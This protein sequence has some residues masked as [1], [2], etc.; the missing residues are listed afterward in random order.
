MKISRGAP[1]KK[2]ARR[3]YEIARDEAIEALR[4]IVRG[5]TAA[6]DTDRMFAAR[7]LLD[8]YERSR[9]NGYD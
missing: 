2:D 4:R 8:H 7:T 1:P 3:A 5:N 6:S 9:V